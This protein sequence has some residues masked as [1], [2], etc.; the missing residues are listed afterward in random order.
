MIKST[1]I[2]TQQTTPLRVFPK[3]YIFEVTKNGEQAVIEKALTELEQQPVDM[4]ESVPVEEVVE[5]SP[6]TFEEVEVNEQE[7][8]K[9]PFLS[10]KNILYICLGIGAVVLFQLINE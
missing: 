6:V 10:D 1:I 3:G 2:R 5:E 9:Q 4:V 8:K 7:V